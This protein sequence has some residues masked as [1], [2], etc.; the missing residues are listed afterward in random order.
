MPD[1]KIYHAGIGVMEKSEERQD[2]ITFIWCKAGRKDLYF[3][4]IWRPIFQE[5]HL[6]QLRA[7]AST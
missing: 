4:R 7:Y 5:Q 2:A 1:G 3:K 6:C